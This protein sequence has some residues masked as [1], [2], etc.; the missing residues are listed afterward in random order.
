MNA[1]ES[2]VFRS[3]ICALLVLLGLT[4]SA[5]AYRTGQPDGPIFYW[6]IL[7]GAPFVLL[8]PF[9]LIPGIPVRTVV[10]AAVG[11]LIGVGLP[12]GLLAYS[13]A[14]YSGGGAN[15]GLGLLLLAQPIYV[16]MAM[17]VGAIL[18]TVA[19]TLG[20]T[21]HPPTRSE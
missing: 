1:Q 12:Y 13:S 21:V 8:A 6:G 7:P 17:V 2:A 14:N 9:A 3:S 16:P 18:G 20:H 5:I 11:G 19:G 10:G 15:I 4:M